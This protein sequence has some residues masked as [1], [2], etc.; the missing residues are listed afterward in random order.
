GT[1]GEFII[2]NP[3]ETP[4]RPGVPIPGGGQD[5]RKP[6]NISFKNLGILCRCSI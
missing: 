3:N 6:H 2:S 1:T 4:A 5:N